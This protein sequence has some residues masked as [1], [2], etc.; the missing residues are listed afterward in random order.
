MAITIYDSFKQ[1]LPPFEQ[2]ATQVQTLDKPSG[3]NTAECTPPKCGIKIP[4]QHWINLASDR[5]LEQHKAD[6]KTEFLPKVDNLIVLKSEAD[7]ADASTLYLTHPVHVAYELVHSSDRDCRID[8]LTRPLR[9]TIPASRADRAYFSKRPL[10]AETP[11][12]STN[13]FAVLEYKKFQGLS[14]SEFNDG[15]VANFSDYATSLQHP[16]F[17]KQESNTAIFLQQATHY[18]GSF[19]TPFVALCD[20]STLILLVMSKV[21]KSH[22]GEVSIDI[23]AFH[24]TILLILLLSLV[25]VPDRG[26]EPGKDAQGIFGIPSGCQTTRAEEHRL[27]KESSGRGPVHQSG[28]MGTRASSSCRQAR[29][30]SQTN[31]KKPRA[32]KC[33]SEQ[34][35]HRRFRW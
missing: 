22:G 10:N 13:I 6:L 25:H 28:D 15:T 30:R 33:L 11:G 5:C 20:Y 17:I 16:P 35:G 31:L 14:R 32:E 9:D 29:K 7:V 26:R 34:S 23:L 24:Q 3:T 1:A 4:V 12:N 27:A 21:E 19:G 8:Q 18:A 2:I